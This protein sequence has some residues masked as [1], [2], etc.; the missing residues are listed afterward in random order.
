MLMGIVEGVEDE[1]GVQ[2]SKDDVVEERMGLTSYRDNSG[3]DWEKGSDTQASDRLESSWNVRAKTTREMESVSLSEVQDPVTGDSLPEMDMDSEEIA[4]EIESG[5]HETQGVGDV[6]LEE[7]EAQSV[8]LEMHDDHFQTSPKLLSF[9]RNLEL[10]NPVYALTHQQPPPSPPH[11]EDTYRYIRNRRE[12]RK[13]DFVIARRNSMSV[14]KELEDVYGRGTPPV[15]SSA[16]HQGGEASED[17]NDERGSGVLRPV[18]SREESPQPG[19]RVVRPRSNPR[20]RSPSHEMEMDEE[21]E[22]RSKKRKKVE[23]EGIS[24]P[25]MLFHRGLPELE[26]V[27]G[28]K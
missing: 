23:V 3:S 25:R 6:A 18:E 22:D 13:E 28:W 26:D 1:K 2:V 16:K 15:P 9:P 19:V 17:E 27:E 20:K 24:D 21:V 5:L 8:E 14:A 11:R 12:Q 10:F 7:T 4:E